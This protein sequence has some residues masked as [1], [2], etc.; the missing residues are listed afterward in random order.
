MEEIELLNVLLNYLN[1]LAS[2]HVSSSIQFK[3]NRSSDNKLTSIKLIVNHN[4]Y[5]CDLSLRYLTQIMDFRSE[6]TI[7]EQLKDIVN[8]YA[9]E[10]NALPLI[11]TTK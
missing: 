6:D 9:T 8:I 5:V 7:I 10:A 3:L 4:L 11:L 2:K 1:E